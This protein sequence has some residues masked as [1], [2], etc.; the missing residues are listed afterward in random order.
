MKGPGRRGHL[1]ASGCCREGG[2]C[3]LGVAGALIWEGAW[4]L[5]ER[6]SWGADVKMR[7]EGQGNPRRKQQQLFHRLPQK[8]DIFWGQERVWET[9]EREKGQVLKWKEGTSSQGKGRGELGERATEGDLVWLHLTCLLGSLRQPG[10]RDPT[11]SGSPVLPA[12][13]LGPKFR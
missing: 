13:W 11:C 12:R 6:E 4:H 5:Q 9:E 7:W 10:S 8:Q 3:R 2:W 1:E